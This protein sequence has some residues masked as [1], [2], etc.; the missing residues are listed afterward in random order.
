MSDDEKIE[1]KKCGRKD[2]RPTIFSAGGGCCENDRYLAGCDATGC[3]ISIDPN[4]ARETKQDA[5]QI[6]EIQI[7]E[8]QQRRN[9]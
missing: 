7:N 9:R 1:L 5:A 4:L 3:K 2:C 8:H 6:W